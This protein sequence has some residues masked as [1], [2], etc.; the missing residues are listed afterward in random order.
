MVTGSTATTTV[1]GDNA[2]STFAGGVTSTGLA[3]SGGLTVSGGSVLVSSSAT[4]TANNGW[5]LSAGCFAINNVCVGSG[6]GTVNS[7]VLGRLAFYPANG[8]TVDDADYLT[9]D[10]ANDRFGIGTTSPLATLSASSTNSVAALFDQRGTSDILQ[11]Q[12]SG[13]TVF[14]VK[15]G[16][17]VYSSGSVGIGSTT[18]SSALAVG[19]ATTATNQSVTIGSQDLAGIHIYGDTDQGEDG[20]SFVHFDTS[21][22]AGNAVIG[23]VGSGAGGDPEGNAL[24]GPEADSLVI[25]TRTNKPIYLGTNNTVYATLSTTG[26]LSLTG[27]GTSTLAGNLDVAGDIEADQFY[28]S[29]SGTS[30]FAGGIRTNLLNVTSTTASSTFANGLNLTGGCFALN[31]GC[32]AGGSTNYVKTGTINRLAYYD[33]TGTI[34][35][36][37]VFAVDATNDRV[38]FG[39][40]SP[41]ATLSA[42]STNAVAALFDQRGTSDILQLQDSGST[43][44]V[45]RDG[46]NVGIG[47]TSPAAKLG[48]IGSA[49]IKQSDTNAGDG[50]RLEHSTSAGNVSDIYVTAGGQ[51]TFNDA[52]GHI[53]NIDGTQALSM[54]SSNFLIS[55]SS[56]N[57]V[58]TVDNNDTTADSVISFDVSGS[59]SF[60]LG[61]DDS[62]SDKFKISAG[63][64]LGVTD[65]FIIDSSGNVGIGTSTPGT[66]LSV[67]SIA[68]FTT[69]TSSLYTGFNVI[70]STGCIAHNGTCISVAGSN[71]WQTTS[72]VVNL[73]TASD[74][75]TIG[76]S[77]EL[78]KL[79]IVGDADEIQLLVRGNGAQS[80]N[81]FVIENSGGTDMFVVN[82]SGQVGINTG[83]A[84][85][86]DLEVD[87]GAAGGIDIEYDNGAFNSGELTF[88][89][90]TSDM[91]SIVSWPHSFT[92]SAIAGDLTFGTTTYS[93]VLDQSGNVG[94]NGSSTPW[95]ALS[96]EQGS[97]GPVFVVSDEGTSTPHLIVDGRGYVGIGTSTPPEKLTIDGNILFGSTA[98]RTIKVIQSV[99]GA[100]QSL[101]LTA[102]AAFSSGTGGAVAITGGTGASLSAG[103]NITIVAGSGFNGGD[104]TINP[105]AGFT[106]ALNGYIALGNTVGNVGVGMTDPLYKLEVQTSSSTSYAA[107]V[108]NT[109]TGT[110]A[111]GL[112]I[113]LGVANASRTTGNYFVGFSTADGTVAGKIQGG[114]SA[115]AYTTTAAD[116]AEFFRFE[117]FSDKPE[118]GDVVMI[119][120]MHD[121]AVRKAIAGSGIAVGVIST[122]PGFIGN[123]PICN[124][125]DEHCDVD[126]EARNV[127][128]AL[129]GQ[130]PVNVSNENGEIQ[131][132]DSLS[133]SDFAG[134]A[135]KAK[136]GDQMI[137][138]ALTSSGSTATSTI[139]MLVSL[140]HAELDERISG[141][142]VG[143]SGWTVDAS[144]RIIASGDADMNGQSIINVAGISSATGDWSITADGRLKA[145]HIVAETIDVNRIAAKRFS[146]LNVADASENTIGNGRIL[147]G[148]TST[149][150]YSKYITA[151]SKI[152]ITF[153]NNLGGRS[154]YIA[155][156]Q[157]PTET[158]ATE[159]MFRIAISSASPDDLNFDWWVVGVDG[160]T[161]SSDPPAGG[162]Q[163][164]TNI[165]DSENEVGTP[166]ESVGGVESDGTTITPPASDS[167]STDGA[168]TGITTNTTTTTTDAPTAEPPPSDP[169]PTDSALGDTTDTSSSPATE[170]ITN[171]ETNPAA[172]D[173]PT[174]TTEPTPD[175]TVDTVTITEEASI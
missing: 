142:A 60:S 18:P 103:G 173:A 175:T 77:T 5:N 146:I 99:S 71:I 89:D 106:T 118:A 113:S 44:F 19:G 167:T 27:T 122:N 129:A 55:D 6:S 72:N 76:G 53:F 121:K 10:D 82:D 29:G 115:V 23:L 49:Y 135:R 34:S 102:G 25:L 30:T 117:G 33:T 174:T 166:T 54:S 111:D 116:L 137:G 157:G 58:V 119:D 123:G 16:G 163:V 92:T 144:G 85:A 109:N 69:G 86:N 15:D 156:K 168:T 45:V 170:T 132:G 46:G 37:N 24:T 162:E 14:Q 52:G 152:F 48:I 65:R 81:Y 84:P 171:T 127:M 2:T 63:S 13:V 133:P 126:Y 165:S 131:P 32:I 147:R 158:G 172:T 145:K 148:D 3:S 108:Y 94:V 160:E 20:G 43:V 22:G 35:S 64:N 143:E 140:G 47:T 80:T 41:L 150:I 12:D 39:T 26:N 112:L 67:D 1:R 74:N 138:I 11:L 50:I 83:G 100:G 141:I 125:N 155:E 107:R 87:T 59:D 38:G 88:K 17:S 130:V 149:T 96:V 90:A 136:H 153:T 91:W 79:A 97:T 159:G 21:S 9:F 70:T 73:I 8:T 51:L 68:N 105:T 124:P 164:P 31:G 75:V 134:F 56:G 78:A 93:L 62:D 161:G 154:W 95:A 7:G 120:I 66:L 40:T 42:S 98:A 101:S 169:T 114:A 151:Q 104:V 110:E 139:T 61:V 28:G 128:V 36:E 57:T 4:S